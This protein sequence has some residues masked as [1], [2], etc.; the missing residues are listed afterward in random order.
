MIIRHRR[1]HGRAAPMCRYCKRD[2]PLEDPDSSWIS[3]HPGVEVLI[4]AGAV[5]F[6]IY[7]ACTFSYWATVAP[8]E[9]EYARPPRNPPTLVQVFKD[10]VRWVAD[11]TRRIW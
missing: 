7:L 1:S 6:V 8:T 10:Q 3:R 5:F 4:I 9:A 2:N 11:L